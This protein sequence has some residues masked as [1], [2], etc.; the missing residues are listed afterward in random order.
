M[1]KSIRKIISSISS[2]KI[3]QV[4]LSF[5]NQFDHSVNFVGDYFEN[6]HH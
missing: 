4:F 5:Q 6:I 3:K 2:S 1:R